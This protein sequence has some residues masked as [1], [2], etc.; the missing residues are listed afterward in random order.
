MIGNL[1]TLSAPQLQAAFDSI[2]P[3][4]L[5]AINGLGMADSSVQSASVGQRIA[6]LAEGSDHGGITSYSMNTRSFR[7]G[8]LLASAGLDDMIFADQ[9]NAKSAGAQNFGSASSPWGFYTS[10]VGTVGSLQSINGGSGLQPGY[11]FNTGG[12]TGG[13][14]YRFNDN[15]VAG[16]SGGYLHGHASVYSPGNATVDNNSGRFGVYAAG[17]IENIRANMYV[18][19][20]VDSFSTSR[21]VAFGNISRTATASPMGSE[22]NTDASASYDIETSRWGTYSPFAGL[23]YDRLMIGSF[24]ESGADSLDL[25]V[26]PETAESLRSSLGAEGLAEV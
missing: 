15:F 19:G 2:S 12:I 25:N 14:D 8:D 9:T 18:G 5:A 24:S 13:A 6:A 3:I 26:S 17:F 1:D 22:F 16:M 7:P 4:S 20:A 21:G 23:N 10:G 11:A